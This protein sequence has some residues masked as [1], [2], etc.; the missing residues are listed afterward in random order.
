[1]A[2]LGGQRRKSAWQPGGYRRRAVVFRHL[3][4]VT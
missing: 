2:N 4:Q 3:L 1:L